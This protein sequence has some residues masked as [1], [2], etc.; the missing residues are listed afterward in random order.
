MSKELRIGLIALIS[1]ALLYYGFN[2]LKGT[3]VFA[4]TNRYFVEYPNTDG[5]AIGSAIKI[6]GVQVGRVSSVVFQPDKNNVL[7][8]LDLQGNIELGDST[9][10]ELAS[11]GLLGG[12]AIILNRKTHQA[13]LEP[14]DYLIPVVDKGL[15]EI[16]EQAQPITDNI[17]ITIRRIN[18]ILLGMEGFGESLTHAV[19]NMDTVLVDVRHILEQNDSKIDSAF[20]KIDGM[21]GKIDASLEPLGIALDN[22]AAVS[23]SLKNSEL[24]ATIATSNKLLKNVNMTL[25]SITN[26]SGTIGQLISNDSLYQNLNKALVDL[27][28]LL[29]HFN[30]YP[31]DFMKPL[32]RK[33]SKLEGLKDEGN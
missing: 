11:D 12:K 14:G 9:I 23:D 29:I 25:D 18:E 10:A 31:R 24:K 19:Q 13:I 27:D 21:V 6:N 32:G 26:S 30:Q 5:L 16:L 33:H 28:K 15:S 4:N 22:M 3:D 17:Q 2:Y 7:V 20:S 1:G 8:E